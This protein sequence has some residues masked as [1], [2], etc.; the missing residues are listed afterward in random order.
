MHDLLADME[1]RTF[2]LVVIGTGV[3]ATSVAHRCRDAGWS[4]AV[5]DSRRFG[6]TCQLR[7]CDPKKV[8]VGVAGAVDEAR[9]LA[10]KG[11]AGQLAI[12]WGDLMRFKRSFTAPVPESTEGSFEEAGIETFHGRARF[13]GETAVE[14]GDYRLEAP[15]F[16][17]AAGA[18]PAPLPIVG[19]EMMTTSDE[20]LDLDRL[21][22]EIV[23]VG[24]GYIAFELAHVARTAGAAVTMLEMTDQPMAGFDTDMVRML[25]ERTREM[26]IELSLESEVSAI[27]ARD[28]QLRVVAN[29]RGERL[30]LDADMVVHGGGRV[31]DIADL[32]LDAARVEHDEDGIIVDQH[33]R[34]VSN[35]A[36]YAAG[37]VVKGSPM[38][39]PVASFEARIVAANLLEGDH[40]RAEY[41]PI[42][43]VVFTLPPLA[44]VGLG[45]AE[46]RERGLAYQVESSP[47]PDWYSSR[48]LG[49]EISGY[50]V[51]IEKPSGRILGAHLFGHHA[52]ELINLFAMAIR[53]GLTAADLEGVIFTYPSRASDAQSMV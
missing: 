10:G 43:S 5:I 6:G 44:T 14:V 19:R 31:P 47:T 27:E 4:V 29:R 39:T 26:G 36:V 20:F 25:V 50:K 18:R 24:S 45:E 2:D 16:H 52:G 53:C 35:R 51:L 46:A 13:T 12:D 8:L 37:D 3:A 23:F 40:R 1:T 32:G 9:R 22:S 15:R 33:M 34:S 17:I 7:G 48:R 30:E 49:E 42:P 41:P 21:P 38:L 11:V 28:G